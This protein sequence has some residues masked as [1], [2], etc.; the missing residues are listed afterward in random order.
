M[1]L[2]P[3]TVVTSLAIAV[4]DHS[5]AGQGASVAAL[6]PRNT[7]ASHPDEL[8]LLGREHDMASNEAIWQS[9]KLKGKLRTA[10]SLRQHS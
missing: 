9:H 1:A 4:V 7:A 10:P 6:V 3:C 5:M 2:V 8:P